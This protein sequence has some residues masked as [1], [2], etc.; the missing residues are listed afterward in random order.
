MKAAVAF[1]EKKGMWEVGEERGA[2]ATTVRVKGQR[3][4]FKA[5]FP[6]VS[7]DSR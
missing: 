1:S 6:Q 3:N 4:L 5:S 2:L 7:H